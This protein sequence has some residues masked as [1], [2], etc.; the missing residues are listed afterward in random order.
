LFLPELTG[1]FSYLNLGL[2]LAIS[3]ITPTDNNMKPLLFFSVVLITL[4][5]C[6]VT[7]VEPVYDYR[8]NVLGAYAM[9]EYSET[10]NEILYYSIR[11]SK[12]YETSDEIYIDNFYNADIR[13]YGY[14]DNYRI[15]I[16]YQV[17]DGYEIEGVGTKSGSAIN[18]S[19]R[20][21]DRYNNY[22]SDFCQTN[23]R[24]TY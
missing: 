14:F 24:R 13:V 20:V 12:S 19:Y 3:L 5:A 17:V 11:I 10:Y 22:R 23:A 9:D 8:D 16:P 4:S 2:K 1:L 6:E 7:V 18:F 15:T 21:K